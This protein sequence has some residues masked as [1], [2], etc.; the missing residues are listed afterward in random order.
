MD[1]NL[2]FISDPSPDL[3]SN[4]NFELPFLSSNLNDILMRLPSIDSHPS[5]EQEEAAGFENAINNEIIPR[6]QR[7]RITLEHLPI[8]ARTRA[9]EA[10]DRNIDS[11]TD[12]DRLIHNIR[13]SARS[14]AASKQKAG[15][16]DPVSEGLTFEKKEE[17]TDFD[18]NVCFEVAKEPVV[19]CCGHLFCW[20]CLFQWLHVHGNVNGECPV[21]KGNVNENSVVPIYGRGSSNLNRCEKVEGL[22]IPPRPQGQ[23]VESFR[24]Q[25]HA[26]RGREMLVRGMQEYLY[27]PE[28]N[29]HPRPQAM[30][31]NNMVIGHVRG[32]TV[33]VGNS[34]DHSNSQAS[35]SSTIAVIE[36][37]VRA[38]SDVSLGTGT[39]GGS[40][41]SMSLRRTARFRGPSSLDS[42]GSD[43]PRQRQ[44]RRRN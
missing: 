16:K 7:E 3:D 2:D 8:M 18:C 42:S 35:T 24:Q 30:V 34:L 1:I 17:P 36:G 11:A 37:E 43:G 5:V 23:R 12:P 19:T 28:F 40:G 44:R 14:I 27:P 39:N 38:N 15:N 4:P 10:I 25:L 33:N 29:L 26:L 9:N 13:R 31:R 22:K 21:C 32:T 41:S 6:P 20:P